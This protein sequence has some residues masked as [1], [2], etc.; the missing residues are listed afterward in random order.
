MTFFP[1]RKQFNRRQ[2][3]HCLSTLPFT[4]ALALGYSS[5]V[6]AAKYQV[7]FKSAHNKYFV[8]ELN[9]SAAVYAN[10]SS[11]GNWEKFHI[12][13]L[14]T[15]GCIRHG[16][17]VTINSGNNWYW[18]PA[19]LPLGG[20]L[21][22]KDLKANYWFTGLLKEA[23]SE[24]K[25]NLV[26]HSDNSGCLAHG[27]QISLQSV[28][29]GKYVVAQSNGDAR[30]D[31]SSIGSWETMTVSIYQELEVDPDTTFFEALL[32]DNPLVDSV[33]TNSLNLA[34]ELLR[35]VGLWDAL[36]VSEMDGGLE[37]FYYAVTSRDLDII[38]GYHAARDPIPYGNTA[39]PYDLRISNHS[40]HD[41]SRQ[42]IDDYADRSHTA[43]DWNKGN[44]GAGKKDFG[45]TIFAQLY[46]AE[47]N[48]SAT[49][50]ANAKRH[51]RIAAEQGPWGTT[52]GTASPLPWVEADYDFAEVR[53]AAILWRFKDLLDAESEQHLLSLI[54]SEGPG[55]L[56]PLGLFST[57]DALG[58]PSLGFMI[59]ETE[60]HILKT[61]GARYLKNKWLRD[62]GNT[63]PQ[64]NNAT[65]GVAEFLTNFIQHTIDATI[66]EYNSMPYGESTLMALMNLE[67]Y[68]DGEVQTK[69]R[70]LLDSM[71]FKYAL[72]SI[73]G[74]RWAPMRRKHSGYGNYSDDDTSSMARAIL[75]N[76]E[77]NGSYSQWTNSE[78]KLQARSTMVIWETAMP[79]RVPQQTYDLLKSTEKEFFVT[80]GRGK[81]TSPELYSAGSGYL[82]TAGGVIA[83]R[84]IDHAF[85][86]VIPFGPSCSDQVM[87]STILTLEDI[88]TSR[89]AE[90]FKMSGGNADNGPHGF[91]VDEHAA[92]DS[93]QREYSYAYYN[94][95]CVYENFACSAARVW[96]PAPT[97][98][99]SNNFSMR[100]QDATN[101]INLSELA[102]ATNR[103][104]NQWCV[105][106]TPDSDLHIGV[107]SSDTLGVMALVPNLN[108]TIEAAAV[109]T[110]LM[111]ANGNENI[112][113]TRFTWPTNII[114]VPSG[115]I[116]YDRHA[117]FD[118]W[119]I[120]G[121]SY[122]QSRF[123]DL[124]RDY[125]DW[126][127]IN[128]ITGTAAPTKN[129][130]R[131]E[132]DNSHLQ[133]REVE[134]QINN[135]W[136]HLNSN[137]FNAAISARDQWNGAHG[138]GR[139]GDASTTTPIYHSKTES[140]TNWWQ[141][142]LT[143]VPGNVQA[144]RILTRADAYGYRINNA[145]ILVG[146]Q[147]IGTW[148]WD[149]GYTKIFQVA[150]HGPY[151]QVTPA[152]S[153]GG[154][155]PIYLDRHELNCGIAGMRGF[156][157]N[158]PA[159]NQIQY[160][161][162]C[163]ATSSA[164]ASG[165]HT[166]PA[167]SDGGGHTAYLDRHGIDCGNKAIKALRLT[168]PS[169]SQFAYHYK[170]GVAGLN[171]VT[172]R[173]TPW[174][175][176]GNNGGNSIYL[177]RQNVACANGEFITYARLQT[178][179]SSRKYRYHYRCGTQ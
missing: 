176:N 123:Q 42:K 16:E 8:S 158:R 108:G 133:L 44:E 114:G 66:Y 157:L 53:L 170:C 31:R 28:T 12:N 82:L 107:Y 11:V 62:N 67:A 18:Q 113:N 135:Q 22:Q 141:A 15:G 175:L 160:R 155:N 104:L 127:Q 79:Y 37:S 87:R 6:Q 116:S 83:D 152:N 20:V 33:I 173:Y 126:P 168:R 88:T 121:V 162:T 39:V 29:T 64:Y 106:T 27:D 149:G 40:V 101:G 95:T 154:G 144:V 24:I 174:D 100:C 91:I 169:G 172:D 1:N 98:L 61:E 140:G 55:G 130:V 178:N 171:N 148:H 89:H 78:G 19:Y 124:G 156:K 99:K 71:V 132:L 166:T 165:W 30:V 105:Y 69:A 38:A 161:Y 153:D 110:G 3:W 51:I 45:T 146:G 32:H 147:Q 119:A 129:T 75:M 84:R 35:E 73:D 74:F 68:G 150:H 9:G 92:A 112:L 23:P 122:D 86:D 118:R 50:L 109:L 65:N 48:N 49:D 52:G 41:L 5:A 76:T 142:V 56:T 63:R 151:E 14:D 10:R 34:E 85:C 117:H 13:D 93:Q 137:H 43:E 36:D 102:S 125:Q 17:Q 72:S 96:A 145:R 115:N 163:A 103:N 164:S 25:F 4:L 138:A 136:Y 26:N 143:D 58:N 97:I 177:D 2:I 94:N 111:A 80:L 60:N 54:I 134:V 159:S 81:L 47:I 128:M 139:A 57:I 7:S 46:R 70:E 131:I 90:G 21:N 77:L 167:N 179:W 59:P 120:T